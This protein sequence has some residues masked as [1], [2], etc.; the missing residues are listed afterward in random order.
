LERK[1]SPSALNSGA[2]KP[3]ET[4]EFEPVRMFVPVHQFLWIFAN[5]FRSAAAKEGAVIEKELQQV[6]VRRAQLATQE[7]IIV[8]PRVE[9]FDKGTGAWNVFHRIEHGV[10]DAMK[11]VGKI[12]VQLMPTL[13]VGIRRWPLSLQQA[14]FPNQIERY[15]AAL[16]CRPP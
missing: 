2:L 6:E 3:R 10:G 9:I 11:F 16:R 14:D 7:E 1:A 12:F 4:H 13:P 8:Q 5:A 15:L